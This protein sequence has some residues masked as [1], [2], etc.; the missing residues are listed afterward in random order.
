MTTTDQ[1]GFADILA[2]VIERIDKPSI[3]NSLK[4]SIAINRI[5]S[6]GIDIV[7]ISKVAQLIFANNEN[8][9]YVED[10]FSQVIGRSV[11]IHVVFENKE[12]YFKKK[13]GY[14]QP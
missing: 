1:D 4:D 12:T 10:I 14:L 5:T 8:M 11:A 9:K 13:L 7:T 3:K 6:E 2:Q